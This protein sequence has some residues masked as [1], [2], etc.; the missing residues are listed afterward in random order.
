MEDPGHG[1]VPLT[2]EECQPRW[3]HAVLVL[4]VEVERAE[5]PHLEAVAGTRHEHKS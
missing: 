2:L 3:G 1:A 5:G 4:S